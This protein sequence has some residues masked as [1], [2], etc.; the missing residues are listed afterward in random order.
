[1]DEVLG[2]KE[3]VD[4]ED[5]EKF[6]YIEQVATT[7]TSKN[8]LDTTCSTVNTGLQGDTSPIWAGSGFEQGGS[9][10]WSGTQRL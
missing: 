2:S 6:Q 5:L 4:A 9:T 1:M 3:C 8:V 10:R 7:C